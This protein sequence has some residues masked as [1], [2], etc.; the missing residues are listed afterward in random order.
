MDN[1]GAVDDFFPNQGRNLN[2]TLVNNNRSY[3]FQA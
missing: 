3:Q 1:K 2:S